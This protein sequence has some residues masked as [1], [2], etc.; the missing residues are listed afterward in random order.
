[1]C[2]DIILFGTLVVN[3]IVVLISTPKRVK[4]GE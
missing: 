1:M 4:G 3:V 2:D